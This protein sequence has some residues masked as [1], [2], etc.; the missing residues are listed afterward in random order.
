M[1][2]D[3]PTFTEK[4]AEQYN[5]PTERNSKYGYERISPDAR[6]FGYDYFPNIEELAD[7]RAHIFGS[8]LAARD[9]GV[10]PAFLLGLGKE[11]A[12]VGREELP[13]CLDQGEA[14]RTLYKIPK[15]ISVTML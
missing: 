8:A 6:P 12:D 11:I 15:W 9:E 10:L 1:Y 2:E 7:A 4:L 13:L 3:K 5:Y 14:F